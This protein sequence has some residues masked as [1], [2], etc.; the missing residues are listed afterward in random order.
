[1]GHEDTTTPPELAAEVEEV[2]MGAQV[3]GSPRKLHHHLHKRL[4]S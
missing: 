3:D 1:M 2:T 4:S